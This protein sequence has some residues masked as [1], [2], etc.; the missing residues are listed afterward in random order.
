MW[1]TPRPQIVAEHAERHRA[2]GHHERG[3]A[4][5]EH[6]LHAAAV[7]QRDAQQR[8]GAGLGEPAH[9]DADSDDPA[10]PQRAVQR[11]VTLCS[12][13]VDAR[14]F[15]GHARLRQLG[16]DLGAGR[17]HARHL[18]AHRDRAV[19][20]LLDREQRGRERVAAAGAPA[21]AQAPRSTRSRARARGSPA[22]SAAPIRPPTH[23]TGPLP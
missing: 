7:A 14:A 1:S 9:T 21:N 2:L 6:R 20:G 8:V 5:V 11:T 12:S 18:E 15:A 16:R 19:R 3:R 13:A 10:A 23:S 17:L 4:G 22:C